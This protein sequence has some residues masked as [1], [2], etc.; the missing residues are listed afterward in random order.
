MFND[1]LGD[2][3]EGDVWNYNQP[4]L[5]LLGPNK[6]GTVLGTRGSGASESACPLTYASRENGFVDYTDGGGVVSLYG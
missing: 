6:I 1:V 2:I 3:V 4:S 5:L